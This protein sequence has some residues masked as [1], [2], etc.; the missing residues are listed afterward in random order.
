[1]SKIRSCG[2]SVNND[3]IWGKFDDINQVVVTCES[4][5]K[6]RRKGALCRVRRTL[7]KPILEGE[8][9]VMK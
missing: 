3:V 8:C 1:M 2:I 4:I 7:R 6:C 9:S 5:K